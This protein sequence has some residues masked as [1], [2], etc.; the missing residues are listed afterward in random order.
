MGIH[1][2]KKGKKAPHRVSI[3]V[4]GGQEFDSSQKSTR[5][6]R[7][8]SGKFSID[9]SN[10]FSVYDSDN[11]F[12]TGGS[13]IKIVSPDLQIYDLKGKI[14]R[15]Q[16]EINRLKAS[17]REWRDAYN[18]QIRESSEVESTA[19]KENTQ[20]ESAVRFEVPSEIQKVDSVQEGDKA[21]TN[22]DKE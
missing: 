17:N 2:E 8:S 13:G 12:G 11:T 14:D 7:D 21:S 19:R 22:E 10:I 9:G 1:R 15:M 4:S 16:S 18:V 5:D 3:R 20:R 6:S